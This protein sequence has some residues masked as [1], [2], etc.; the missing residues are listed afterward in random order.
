MDFIIGNKNKGKS[1]NIIKMLNDLKLTG[2][3][4]VI[5]FITYWDNET[6]GEE[7]FTAVEFVCRDGNTFYKTLDQRRPE[8]AESSAGESM[9]D[10]RI[11]RKR[12]PPNRLVEENDEDTAGNL[13]ILSSMHIII[14]LAAYVCCRPI[15]SK[16]IAHKLN[17]SISD[18]RGNLKFINKK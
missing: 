11:P 1:K 10:R 5:N 2:L 16:C 18:W 17:R 13:S 14:R 12:V 9:A 4:P 3:R 15:I 7:S 8:S 6:E